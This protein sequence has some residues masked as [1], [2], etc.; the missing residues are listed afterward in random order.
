MPRYC[1]DREGN[2]LI[3]AQ[4]IPGTHHQN[5]LFVTRFFLTMHAGKVFSV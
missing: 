2:G 3:S 1:K 5:L 4:R